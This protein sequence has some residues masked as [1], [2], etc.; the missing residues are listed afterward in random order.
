MNLENKPQVKFAEDFIDFTSESGSTYHAVKLSTDLLEASGFEELN[1]KKHWNIELGKKYF[2]KRTDST[3][4]AFTI[5]KE[6]NESTAFRIVGSHTDSP[7]FKIKPRPEQKSNGFLRLNT[8]IY[9]A[10]IISTWFDRPLGVAGR[11]VVKSDDTFNPKSINVKIDRALMTIPNL[12]IHQ[13]RTVNEGFNFDKQNDVL[14]I[15]TLLNETLEKDDFLLKIIS[16]TY[17]IELESILD[18]DL[19]LYTYEKGSLLGANKEFISA[20]RI[21]NLASVFTGLHGLIESDNHSHHINVLAGFDNEEIGSSSKQGANSNYLTNFLERIFCSLAKSREA[22]LESIYNSFLI[23]ADGAHA[24][25]PAH[26]EKSDPVVKPRVNEGVVIKCSASQKYTSDGYSISVIKQLL[27]NKL[28][29]QYFVNN[30]KFRGGSTIGPLSSTHFDTDSV[31]L[32]VPMLGM[33]SVTELCGVDDLHD[34]K[35][36]LRLFWIEK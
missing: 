10:P 28:K 31:D 13:N 8:E 14:P 29:L 11:V 23:S 7:C 35:E 20:P 32:G 9:G 27:D 22:F 34:L 3:F 36:L 16:E 6:V 30:S 25:H 21:D 26:P 15:I 12:A 19:F 33:H 18:F 17:N 4:I 5:P 24:V 1:H 2:V